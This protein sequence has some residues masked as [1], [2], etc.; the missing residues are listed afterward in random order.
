ME[1]SIVIEAQ[2][3]LNWPR[4]KRLVEVA[5]TLPLAGLYRTDHFTDPAPPDKDALELIVSLSYLAASTGRIRFGPLVAPVSFRDPRHLARQA[6]ALDDLS[7]G[8]M[9]LG[10]GAGWQE[11]E[12]EVYGY[13]LGDMR[14]RARRLEEA[15]E[16]TTHLLRGEEPVTFEGEHLTLRGATLL[17]RPIRSGGPPVLVGGSGPRRTLPLVARYADVWNSLRSSPEAFRERSRLLDRLVLAE[18]RE[19]SDVRRTLFTGIFFAADA[20]DLEGVLSRAREHT[21]GYAGKG[22][23]EVLD[24]LR[25]RNTIVGTPDQV[26]GQLAEFAA[27][28]VQEIMLRWTEMDDLDRLRE[29]ARA[30]APTQERR[31]AVEGIGPARPPRW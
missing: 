21:P 9:V 1:V 17:P 27:A 15:L 23:T 20:R 4:W 16:V 18:G 24:A 13:P 25:A 19:P 10:L 30:V 29:F 22:T 26:A 5:D 14:T 6:A 28:G 3:G 11:R 2:Q 12:H 31:S 8:R 7:G